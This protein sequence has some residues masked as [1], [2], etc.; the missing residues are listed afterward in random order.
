METK[1]PKLALYG[2]ILNDTQPYPLYGDKIAV[3]S[4]KQH[5]GPIED[6]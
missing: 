5:R 4:N 3:C 1:G 6:P 2:K